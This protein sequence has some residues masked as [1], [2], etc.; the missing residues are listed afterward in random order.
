MSSVRPPVL[1]FNMSFLTLVTASSCRVLSLKDPS[2]K[3][4]KSSPDLNSRI[5]LTDGPAQ[6]GKKIRG[7][8]TDSTLGITYDPVTRPGAANLLSIFASCTGEEPETIAA[9][10]AEKGHGDLK[11]DVA[12]AVEELIKGPRAEFERLRGE[13]AYLETVAQEGAAKAREL[14]GGTMREGRAR[15]GLV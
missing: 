12:E 2:S 9:R 8:V 5:L 3:M 14:T 4:S 11:A 6:V 7:A 13:T 1:V 10:Y 15:I